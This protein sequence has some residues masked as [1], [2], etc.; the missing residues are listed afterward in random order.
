MLYGLLSL[1]VVRMLPVALSLVGAGVRWPTVGFLG[2]FGPRGLASILFAL[3]VLEGSE[4]PAAD[5]ILAI[6]VVTV[7]FSILAHG[8]T[9]APAARWY[10]AMAERMGECEENKPVGE[11]P[12]R[13]RTVTTPD[14]A[15]DP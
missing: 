1:T 12:T 11:M 10:G 4:M 9:A 5:Q 7:T 2:W 3:F 6:T 13:G 14:M 8:M 15:V